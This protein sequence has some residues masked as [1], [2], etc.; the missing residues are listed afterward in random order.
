MIVSYTTKQTKETMNPSERIN[1]LKEDLELEVEVIESIPQE[2]YPLVDQ[3]SPTGVFFEICPFA[4]VLEVLHVLRSAWGTYEIGAYWCDLDGN[5]LNLTY[6]FHLGPE[7]PITVFF[8]T[9]E[10]SE[11]LDKISH[12]KCRLEIKPRSPRTITTVVCDN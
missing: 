11:A 10:V 12:G 4:R 5:R 3:T 9:K 1:K 7:R 8:T 6:D 2:L